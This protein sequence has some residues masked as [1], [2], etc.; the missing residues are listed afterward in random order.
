MSH[1][2][3]KIPEVLELARGDGVAREQQPAREHGAEPVE[4]EVEVPE[5]GPEQLGPGH[6]DPSVTCDDRE[7]GHER[8]L[9]RAAERVSLHLCDRD[10]REV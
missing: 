9:E 8:E 3:V 7:V 6:T 1:T 4:E 5:R 2:S 10:L